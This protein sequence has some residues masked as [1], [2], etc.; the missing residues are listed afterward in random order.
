[1]LRDILE[2]AGLKSKSCA[3][4][5]GLDHKLF[6]EWVMGQRP[7][8]AYIVPELSSVLGVPREAILSFKKP[9]AGGSL[10][11]APAIWFK[12]RSGDKLIEAD[13]EIV[14]VI[15]RL[16]HFMDELEELTDTRS[17]TWK[18]LF[19]TIRREVDKQASPKDQGKTAA[20]IIRVDRQFGHYL[21]TGKGIRAAGDI[22][23]D[24]LRIMGIRVIETPVPPSNLEGCSFY[25]GAP[26]SERPCLFANSYMQTWFR[27]NVVLMHELAH[28]IFDIDRSAASLDFIGD[29]KKGQLEEIRAQAFAQEVLVPREVLNHIA[30]TKGLKWDSLSAQDVATL[31]ACS[32]VEQLTVLRAAVEAGF[33]SLE[34]A[35]R[36]RGTAIHDHLKALTERALS[37][38]EY[39]AVHHLERSK[40]IPAEWR[41]TTIPAR[42]LRLP[43]PYVYKV[44]QMAKDSDISYG[45]AA[46][47][48]MVEKPTFVERF[49]TMLSEA[50]A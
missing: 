21:E 33:M 28:A 27:R 23:R 50:A 15:R 4:L 24:N 19:E 26:G 20:R 37:T 5:L 45:K 38:D 7:I 32:Q 25:V 3:D 31:V 8:P 49:G 43:L 46:Q 44:L 14:V 2:S 9:E 29:G 17:I 22:L 6:Q 40:M 48:L 12:F 16:A 11:N 42:A 34:S 10:E 13:R 36:Y 39:I 41:T 1:M 47:M 35:E 30:Q 18:A